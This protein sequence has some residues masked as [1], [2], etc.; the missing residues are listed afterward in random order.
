MSMTLVILGVSED[1]DDGVFDV[2]GA[3]VSNDTLAVVAPSA[4]ESD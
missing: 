1:C 4:S 3:V 2:G